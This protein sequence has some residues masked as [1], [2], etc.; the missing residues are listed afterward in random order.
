MPRDP[1][2]MPA[3]HAEEWVRLVERACAEHGPTKVGL[4]LG[5]SPATVIGVRDGT[6]AAQPDRVRQAVLE[7]L[8]AGTV[9]CPVLGEIT[10]A[11]C[12]ELR[13]AP[14]ST[15]NPQRVRLFRACQTCPNNPNAAH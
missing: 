6:Y 8:G 4:L 7:R 14:F 9:A 3:W 2:A 11:R 15:S 12:G 5:Y 13:R 1:K 10:L